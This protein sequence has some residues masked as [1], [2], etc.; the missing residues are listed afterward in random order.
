[1]DGVVAQY[2]WVCPKC[3]TVYAPFVMQ[4]LTCGVA[5]NPKEEVA[6]MW[7]KLLTEDQASRG[8]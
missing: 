5:K 7:R 4:C 1:M 8:E 3:G 2:G 6:P